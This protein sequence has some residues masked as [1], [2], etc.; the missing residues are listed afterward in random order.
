MAPVFLWVGHVVAATFSRK[1]TGF[2]GF[3][4]NRGLASF[5]A[6]TGLDLGV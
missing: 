1:G 4:M 3:G 6:I 5:G 2:P